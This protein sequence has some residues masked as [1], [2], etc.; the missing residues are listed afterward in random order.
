MAVSRLRCGMP[1]PYDLRCCRPRRDEV[2]HCSP[3]QPTS[4]QRTP[5]R[6][7]TH[8]VVSPAAARRHRVPRPRAPPV[9]AA[10]RVRAHCLRVAARSATP[11]PGTLVAAGPPRPDLSPP[12]CAGPASRR[13]DLAAARPSGS[14]L[15]PPGLASPPGAGPAS[16]RRHLAADRPP[17]PDL[18]PAALRHQAHTDTTASHGRRSA[19]WEKR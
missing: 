14:A 9:T 10:C 8:D 12:L 4:C 13:R 17:R 16:L 19:V 3:C 5:G 6:L 18:A 1:L 2:F 15:P 7:S 11:P